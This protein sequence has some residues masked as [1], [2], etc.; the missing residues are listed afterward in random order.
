[1]ACLVATGAGASK[2]QG[3]DEALLLNAAEQLRTR[4]L[5]AARATLHPL[6]PGDLDDA[7]AAAKKGSIPCRLIV[8]AET[9]TRGT[10][11]P[12]KISLLYWNVADDARKEERFVLARALFNVAI[13]RY[14]EEPENWY[15]LGIVERDLGRFADSRQSLGHVLELRPSHR[16]ALYWTATDLMDE[17][18]FDESVEILDQL[19]ASDAKDGRSWYRRGQVRVKQGKCAEAAADLEKAHAFKVDPKMIK[20]QLKSCAQQ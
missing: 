1:M 11:T 12:D 7:A 9:E 19:I 18:K 16:D 15:S 5:S 3:A 2:S 17:G 10:R 6:C 20:Q 4:D 8:I 14:P 13:E